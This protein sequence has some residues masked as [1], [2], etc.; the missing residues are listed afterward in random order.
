MNELKNERMKVMKSIKVIGYGLMVIGVL[1]VSMPAMAQWGNDNQVGASAPRTTFQSTSSM[2]G[3][4]SA[5]SSNPS[6]G[7][8]GMA[9]AP[10]HRSLGARRNDSGGIGTP[11]A[12]DE[13]DVINPIGDAILPLLMAAGAFLLMKVLRRRRAE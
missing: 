2:T 11:D 1:L 6:I 10:S 5:Y 12:D 8:N 3:S 13:D 7:D 4:N 9:A